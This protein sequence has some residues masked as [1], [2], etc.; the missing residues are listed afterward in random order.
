MAQR[1][2]IQH[3]PLK[4]YDA[5]VNVVTESSSNGQNTSTM[6]YDALGRLIS[7]KDIGSSCC[8]QAIL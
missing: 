5:D 3:V 7:K 2:E 1:V 6:T 4:H 8:S